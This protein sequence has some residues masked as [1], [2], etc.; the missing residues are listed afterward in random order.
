MAL[1]SSLK[2]DLLEEGTLVSPFT[3][4]DHSSPG[5]QEAGGRW[6]LTHPT[7]GVPA[8]RN[9]WVSCCLTKLLVM[10]EMFYSCTVQ[11]GSHWPHVAVEPL[12][13]GQCN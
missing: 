3:S 5:R 12:K 11:Y 2:G 13:H 9:L 1:A 8:L 10:L 7:Q 6:V 4:Q